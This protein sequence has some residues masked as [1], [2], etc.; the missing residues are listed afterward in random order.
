MPRSG[1]PTPH[2]WWRNAGTEPSACHPVCLPP[3]P[4]LNRNIATS[5]FWFW[6]SRLSGKEDLL[7]GFR[8]PV[9]APHDLRVL[10]G[11]KD[12]YAHC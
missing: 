4:L 1:A 6:I 12:D 10:G 9:Q 8:N 5:F 7:L 3:P 2:G 11:V